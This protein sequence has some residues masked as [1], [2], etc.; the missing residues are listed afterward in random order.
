MVLECVDVGTQSIANY[1]ASSG[2]DTID[3]LR[4]AGGELRGLPVVHLSATPYGG[5]VVAILRSKVPLLRDLRSSHR[6]AY[7]G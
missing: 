2:A 4:E 6:R 7:D 1:A 5:G 3:A